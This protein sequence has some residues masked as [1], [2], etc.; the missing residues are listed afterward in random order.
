MF[1]GD[2]C[3]P[4]SP[5]KDESDKKRKN[6]KEAEDSDEINICRND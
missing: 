5:Y 1:K 6:K 2:S 4:I 3:Y